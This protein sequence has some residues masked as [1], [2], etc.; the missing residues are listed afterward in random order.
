[1]HSTHKITWGV[2][3]FQFPTC[4]G[5]KLHL[6]QCGALLHMTDLDVV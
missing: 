1:M 3:A 5:W 6:R 2:G 4:I